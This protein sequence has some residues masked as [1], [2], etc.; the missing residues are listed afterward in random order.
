MT[1][2]EWL[3]WG[4]HTLATDGRKMV[5]AIQAFPSTFTSSP[6]LLE[7]LFLSRSRKKTSQEIKKKNLLEYS[8]E[9]FVQSW[10]GTLRYLCLTKTWDFKL[11]V[12]Q[13]R[14][15]VKAY[16][17]SNSAVYL[18]FVELFLKSTWSP[19]IAASM[20]QKHLLWPELLRLV[21]K[22]LSIFTI[23]NTDGVPGKFQVCLKCSMCI[24]SFNLHW[25]PTC[26]IYCLTLR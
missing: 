4:F 10:T 2:K 8:R 19:T 26:Y 18:W 17:N 7:R 6:F 13:W 22:V 23:V 14:D 21:S 9:N 16:T 15:K 3:I 5:V 12:K 24:K 25:N 11:K 20:P 1:T